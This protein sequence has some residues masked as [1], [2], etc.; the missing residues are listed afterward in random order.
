[1]KYCP[2][3]FNYLYLDNPEGDIYL[4]PWMIPQKTCIGNLLKS[5]IETCYNSN[6]ANELR[7]S[8]KDQSF[9]L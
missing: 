3:V 5:D 2:V 8:I 1:M 9:R 6:F 4:C 7:E